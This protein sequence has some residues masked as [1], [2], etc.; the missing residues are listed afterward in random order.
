MGGSLVGAGVGASVGWEVGKSRNSSGDSAR[1][2]IAARE[3]VGGEEQA[4]II[5]G[6][7]IRAKKDNWRQ[8]FLQFSYVNYTDKFCMDGRIL[9]NL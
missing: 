8:M 7:K 4:E 3:P 9:M 2:V 5:A 1:G 6:L